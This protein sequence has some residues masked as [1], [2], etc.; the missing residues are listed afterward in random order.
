[1]TPINP[2]AAWS[3]SDLAR[4]GPDIDAARSAARIWLVSGHTRELPADLRS[5]LDGMT[6]LDEREFTG[7]LTVQLLAGAGTSGR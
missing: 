1:M 6:V 2:S 5:L 7:D 3:Q 4:S